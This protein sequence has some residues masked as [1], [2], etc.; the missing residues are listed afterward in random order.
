[1][2]VNLEDLYWKQIFDQFKLTEIVDS[3]PKNSDQ[4]QVVLNF[5]REKYGKFN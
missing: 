2:L 4:A 1:M 3:F 5:L